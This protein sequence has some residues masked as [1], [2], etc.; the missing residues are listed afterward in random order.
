M[1]HRPSKPGLPPIWNARRGLVC[2]WLILAGFAQTL[3]AIVLSAASAAL[4]TGQPGIY[5]VPVL[6]VL[7]SSALVTLSA[8]VLQTRGA[9][10]FALSYVH[11]VRLTYAR[12]VMLLPF[13]GKTPSTGLSLTRLVNDLGAVKLWLSRGLLSLLTLSATLITLAGWIGIASPS[14]LIPLAACLFIWGT[15]TALALP[16]LRKS[17]R[18]SRQRR[19]AIAILLGRTLPERLPLLLHGKL[20]PILERLSTKS[21]EVCSLLVARA[22]WSGAMKAV[23]RATFPAAVVAYALSGDVEPGAI[24]QFLLIFAFLAAQL[25]AGAV[26]LEYHEA[27][28]VAREK[29]KRVFSADRLAPLDAQAHLEPDWSQP[30]E[31]SGLQ[32]PSGDLLSLRIS[33]ADCTW[34]KLDH[35]GDRRHVALSLCGLTQDGAQR[36]IRLAGRTFADIDRKTLWRNVTLVSP[37]NGIPSYQKNRPAAVLGSRT[38][39]K[40]EEEEVFTWF[41]GP[42]MANTAEAA[43]IR[44]DR[45]Q[46][47]VRIARALLRRPRLLVVQDDGLLGEKDLLRNLQ[48]HARQRGMAL[49]LLTQRLGVDAF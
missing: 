46:I 12:H 20:T 31:I 14:Y 13:D 25:E 48:E 27:N 47:R 41:P 45:D 39:D 9:E 29:I 16:G 37:I 28:K 15:G 8:F 23:S 40:A 26:G 33:P 42:L 5:G 17:I 3:G 7:C 22:T 43:S 11:D 10:R 18:K 38:T 49:V 1:S 4:L 44:S 35:P 34:L 30:V 32:L 19:G 36:N 2:A 6:A 21:K 24:A